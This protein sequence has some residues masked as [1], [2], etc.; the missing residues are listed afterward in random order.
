M[1]NQVNQAIEKTDNKAAKERYK[2]FIDD[3]K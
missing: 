3:I 2:S 1:I